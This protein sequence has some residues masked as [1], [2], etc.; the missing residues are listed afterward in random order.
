[1]G[2]AGGQSNPLASAE[3]NWLTA[4]YDP[5]RDREGGSQGEAADLEA[6]SIAPHDMAAASN[7]T[8]AG[9]TGQS[10]EGR[11]GTGGAEGKGQ[12][13][14]QGR[15]GEVEKGAGKGS[16]SSTYRFILPDGKLC[17]VVAESLTAE[18]VLQQSPGHFL[19]LSARRPL[20]LPP[21]T[22]LFRW[23]TY[24]V[25]KDK[26]RGATSLDLHHERKSIRALHRK[27]A[28][29]W[30]S[31]PRKSADS[32][33]SSLSSMGFGS[34]RDSSSSSSGVGGSG[35]RSFAG[36]QRPG[37]RSEGQG[38]MQEE[39]KGRD[40]GGSWLGTSFGGAS[41]RTPSLGRK[42][43]C[44]PNPA[45]ASN[46]RSID[47]GGLPG[48]GRGAAAARKED[49]GPKRRSLDL[50]G[51]AFWGRPLAGRPLH[52]LSADFKGAL[53]IRGQAR[54]RG[55]GQPGKGENQTGGDESPAGSWKEWTGPGADGV[56]GGSCAEEKGERGEGREGGAWGKSERSGGERGAGASRAESGK[57]Q[58][59]FAELCAFMKKAAKRSKGNNGACSSEILGSCRDGQR[60]ERLLRDIIDNPARAAMTSRLLFREQRS[61]KHTKTHTNLE[62]GAYPE[63]GHP[64]RLFIPSRFRTTEVPPT[65]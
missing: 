18:Q 33:N 56:A 64:K 47:L 2:I 11:R 48:T 59:T 24:Y 58:A 51:A 26:G 65:S 27:Q 19:S 13:V 16:E 7:G 45:A 40:T 20:K 23:N 8:E 17:E 54:G 12:G 4:G 44:T 42:D 6:P 52:R 21:D 32:S 25:H 63:D 22:K 36:L 60:S 57:A 3:P 35:R 31:L 53:G 1:M 49:C 38:L 30:A 46:R 29:S 5:R 9:E 34:S 41:P 10:G 15:R 50:S 28:L 39:G 37:R 43:D 62:P 61:P 55:Q 14:G